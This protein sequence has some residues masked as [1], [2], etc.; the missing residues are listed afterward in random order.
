MK[1]LFL[2]LSI[3]VK[4][5]FCII[6]REVEYVKISASFTFESIGGFLV[7]ESK[8]QSKLIKELKE[9]FPGCIVLKNDPTYIQ[10]IP[11]LLILYNDKW[12]SLEVKR[13]ENAKHRPNQDYYVEKMNDMSFSAF[14]FPENK[15]DVLHDLEQALS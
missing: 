4:K 3:I 11:D 13:Q 8:F 7:L 14:I 1:K 15:E 2:E 12:A 10:G 6:E 5:S 9:R